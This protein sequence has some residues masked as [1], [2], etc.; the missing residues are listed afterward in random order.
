[1]SQEDAPNFRETTSCNC[2]NCNNS[3]FHSVDDK[4]CLV[5]VCEKYGFFIQTGLSTHVCDGWEEQ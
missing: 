2:M 5:Y 4:D 3:M 1:M